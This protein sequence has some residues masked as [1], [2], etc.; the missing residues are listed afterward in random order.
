MTKLL[1]Q[2]IEKARLLPV[3]RQDEAAQVL[4][5]IVEQSEPDAPQLNDEQIAEVKRRRESR[6]YATEEEVAAFFYSA[7]A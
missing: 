7:T 4:L 6:N 5:S 3:E 2:A 1:E